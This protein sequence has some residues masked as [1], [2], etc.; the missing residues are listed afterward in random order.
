MAAFWAFLVI[1]IYLA[2]AAACLAAIVW[3]MRRP[4]AKRPDRTATM[5]AF[6]AT[7][8]WAATSAASG[9]HSVAGVLTETARNLAWIIVLY[10]LFAHD[11]RDRGL[12]GGRPVGLSL[13]FVALLQPAL[14]YVAARWAITEDLLEATIQTGYA[15][16]M[17]VAVGA[18][19]LLHNLYAGAESGTRA[20]LRW[21]AAGLAGF[22]AVELNYFTF[23]YVA[24]APSPQFAAIRAMVAGLMVVP[25]AAGAANALAG[26]KLRASHKVAFQSL[27][28]LVIGAY[29]AVIIIA[30]ELVSLLD[31]DVGLFAQMGF[32]IAAATVSLLWLPSERLRGWVRVTVL[33]HLFKHR[34]D[35]RVEWMRFTDTIGRAN[36]AES[37][38]AERAAKAIAD[39]I[40]SPGAILFLPDEEGRMVGCAQWNW[41]G[42][43]C[44]DRVL[45]PEFSAELFRDEYIVEVREPGTSGGAERGAVPAMLAEDPNAWILIPLLHF[46]RKIGAVLLHRP[47]VPRCLDWEDY[48]LLKV[49]ARQ[50]AS[51][52]AEHEGHRALMEAAK[53]DDF[54]RRMAFVM[55]D[56][57]NLASQLQ[58]LSKN[59][60]KHADNPEFRKDMLVTLASST[61]KLNQLLTRLGRYGTG[62]QVELRPVDLCSVARRVVARF[63]DTHPVAITRTENC[64]VLADAER[65]EQAVVHLVQ[66]AIDASAPGM[67]VSLDVYSDGLHG[68]LEIIDSGCGMEAEFV[69]N[70]LFKP[71]VSSKEN[72]F[73]IGALEARDLVR[74]MRGRLDVE[75][76]P[77]IG[78]RFAISLP[79]AEA[80]RFLSTDTRQEVA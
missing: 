46:D 52:L 64:P 13:A 66:N 23:A 26:R 56:I 58:L 80:A 42:A 77:R 20:A 35:Y 37:P 53:F 29:L 36:D 68:K 14:L 25:L 65:L 41:S 60:E 4:V 72:G 70:R 17:L 19:V 50:L 2:S 28:L 57:K 5:V 74:A 24:G 59:A 55:H 16:H 75:S 12:V 15:L 43:T 69:R 39:I 21:S 18:L 8:L 71:F 22:W 47:A 30:A 11:G 51:Y 38:L 32:L 48:D 78:T 34:Y 33:K 1:S 67:P 73:G 54:N 44:A 7:A 3:V 45:D 40:Q 62:Q 49:A 76:R 31:G 10:R 6:A 63:A 79:L 61:E 9:S 27:S